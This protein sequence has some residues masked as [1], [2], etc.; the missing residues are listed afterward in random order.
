M[1]RGQ[2]A[3]VLRS[4]VSSKMAPKTFLSFRSKPNPLVGK[5]CTKNLNKSDEL[6]RM[7]FAG[8]QVYRMLKDR[9]Q[10]S[11]SPVNASLIDLILTRAKSPKSGRIAVS[12]NDFSLAM[13][14]W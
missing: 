2:R 1:G 12:K 3:G 13:S 14:K 11:S 5:M 10:A 6:L 8:G 7:M 9:G 4:I